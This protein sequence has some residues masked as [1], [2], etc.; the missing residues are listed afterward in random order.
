[1]KN[2]TEEQL[3]QLIAHYIVEYSADEIVPMIFEAVIIQDNKT[4]TLRW[5]N[6]AY[7]VFDKIRI[8]YGGDICEF[9]DILKIKG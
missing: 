5:D 7:D 4:I 6:G 2:L 9:V 1:M 8:P 3:G